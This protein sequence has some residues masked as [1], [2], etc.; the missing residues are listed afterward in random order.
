MTQSANRYSQLIEA[1]FLA[2]YREGTNLSLRELRRE[3][4][5]QP[6]STIAW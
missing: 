6:K 5:S 2:R 1:I 4:V 3:S